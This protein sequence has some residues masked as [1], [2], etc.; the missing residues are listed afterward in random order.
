MDKMVLGV[1]TRRWDGMQACVNSWQDTA[2]C[3][4]PEVYAL[5]MDV[6]DAFQ[7]IYEHSEEP[8][9]SMMHDDLMVHEQDWDVRVLKQFDDPAVG[10][11]G[12]A[13]A[14]GHGMPNLY[15]EPFKIPNLVR[16]DFLSNLRNAELHGHRFNGETRVAVLDGLAFF[17][18]RSVIDKWGG[19]PVHAP[20]GYWMYSEALCCE[21]R[22]QGLKIGWLE[23]T[24]TT[25]A[26][27]LR[28]SRR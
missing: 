4:Y 8:I 10:L 28:P 26:E 25:W 19:W 16:R 15:R 21:T 6:M 7:F 20:Y 11:V 24:A 9:I 5:D 14:L 22:R 18:R 23:L 2:S 27:R 17:V 13:G 1:A 12:F 3:P